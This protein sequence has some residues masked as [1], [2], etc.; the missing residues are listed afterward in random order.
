MVTVAGHTATHNSPFLLQR[1]PKSSPVLIAWRDGQA[2]W[3]WISWKI[4]GWLHPVICRRKWSKGSNIHPREV[5]RVPAGGQAP[6][7][8]SRCAVSVNLHLRQTDARIRRVFCSGST[9]RSDVD[10]AWRRR[11]WWTLSVRSSLRLKTHGVENR[12]RFST[13]CVFSLR[14]SLTL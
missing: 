4:P 2:E 3:A 14:W 5:A 8:A 13:P 11:S 7:S 10:T 9:S 12:R 1:W 6:L